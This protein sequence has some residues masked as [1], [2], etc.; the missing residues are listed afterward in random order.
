[1]DNRFKF[2][3]KKHY[4]NVETFLGSRKPEH[5]QMKKEMIEIAKENDTSVFQVIFTM[6]RVGLDEYQKTRKGVK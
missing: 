1:M 2:K 4:Y 5:L 6:M 3:Q